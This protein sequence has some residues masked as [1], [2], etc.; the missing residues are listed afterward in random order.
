MKLKFSLREPMAPGRTIMERFENLA[1]M[2]FSGI[3]ITSSSTPD[4]LE[5]ILAA[6]KA[7]GIVPNIFSLG[8]GAILDARREERQ[9]AIDSL[10]ASLEMCG[11][12]GGV[13][14]IVPPLIH[15]KMQNRPRIP[16]LSPLA[17][18]SKLEFDLFVAIMKQEIV[19]VCEK[20][21]ACVIIEPLNRYEQ[22]WPCTLA[23][24]ME[25]CEA[26]GSPWVVIMADFFH[27]NIEEANF[28]A[29]IRQA[30]K[31]IRN[32]HLADSQRLLP[33]YGHTA[34][35]EPLR[36]LQEIG[37]NDYM[38]FEC[39]IPGDPFVE[40]PKSMDYLRSQLEG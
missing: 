36:A 27:M 21:K 40:L 35:G 12:A 29:S 15:V 10:K 24:G 2:G 16:D 11:A 22:W 25:I 30:G 33:G 31:W 32:V 19:P 3:E 18:T 5:E 37:Y 8:G 38:G 9:I 20:T 26:V 28:A 17:G 7:T 4:K 14:V 6:S 13:G 23:Q 1:K 34:F 39:G